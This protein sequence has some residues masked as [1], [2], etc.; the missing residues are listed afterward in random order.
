MDD[1][2]EKA[3]LNY[4]EL[5]QVTK[6]HSE[7][8]K[9]FLKSA[10]EARALLEEDTDHSPR[11]KATPISKVKGKITSFQRYRVVVGVLRSRAH[12]RNYMY[13]HADPS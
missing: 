1:H 4:E 2:L 6:D 8:M 13:M 10:K 11:T 12:S 3:M 5:C 9:E 7:I